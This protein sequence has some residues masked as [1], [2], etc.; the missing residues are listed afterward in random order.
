[1]I[2]NYLK[3]GNLKA[4][5]NYLGW[6]YELCGKV[7]KGSG[8]GT[9][10]K[11]PTANI[12]PNIVNQLIPAKGVYCVDVIIEKKIYSGMCNIGVRPTFHTNG[13]E[14]IEVHLISDEDLSLYGMN[15]KIIF[16][17][18]I[19]KEKKYKN[20]ADLTNQLGLDRNVC[21]TM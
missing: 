17:K 11:F 20:I 15:I 4:A 12:V 5:N 9:D 18:F 19:R 8:R 14:I 13:E 2:R 21:T 3:E 1:M 16:K 6:K 10:I 7:V